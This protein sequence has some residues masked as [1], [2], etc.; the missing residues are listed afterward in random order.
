MNH[1]CDSESGQCV[2]KHN[3]A[4][5]QCDEC[6]VSRYTSHM[7]VQLRFFCFAESNTVYSSNFLLSSLAMQIFRWDVAHVNVIK[8]DRLVHFV[9]RIRVNVRVKW[10]WK[11]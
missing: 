3:Y 4:G 7:N 6:A 10:A 9:I 1:I 2:C 8:V 5:H 11:D